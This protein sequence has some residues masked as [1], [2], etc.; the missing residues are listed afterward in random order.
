MVDRD[1]WYFTNNRKYTVRSRYQVER[2]YQDK[3]KPQEFFGPTVDNLK[4]FCL[5]VRCP[6][7]IKHFPWQL[8][9]ECIAVKKNLQTRE[10]QRDICCA[11]CGDS[12]ESINHVFFEFLPA[13]QVWMLSK[14]PSNLDF[15]F[16]PVHF[17]QTW[18]IF[19]EELPRKWMIINL[20]GFYGT[21]GKGEKT[22]FLI[23]W[24]WIP[25]IR[26]N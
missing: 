23:I 26:S 7:K 5:K 6:P 1:G 22:I 12:E 21:S 13:R 3:D 9:S 18:I 25:G 8:V 10:I 20:H 24:M 19:F 4:A 17:T 16:Q 11:R 2:V 15:F 14:I